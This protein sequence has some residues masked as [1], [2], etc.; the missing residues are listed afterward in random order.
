[1][2]KKYL[3]EN[4]LKIINYILKRF[5]S[6][7]YFINKNKA[8]IIKNIFYNY[9]F[10]SIISTNVDTINNEYINYYNKKYKKLIISNFI[11][12]L[13]YISQYSTTIKEFI[14]SNNIS[15]ENY[16]H[17]YEILKN[18]SLSNV[19]DYNLIL[20]FQNINDYEKQ[21]FKDSTNIKTQTIEHFINTYE[22]MFQEYYNKKE[23]ISILN[24]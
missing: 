7:F 24:L 10:K 12:N 13:S 14:E 5:N 9:T 16:N 2:D 18:I 6:D 15:E 8:S 11:Y 4:S 17:S 1:M 19:N 23:A 22:N 3:N 21:Y 20:L